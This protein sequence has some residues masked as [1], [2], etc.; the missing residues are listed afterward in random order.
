MRLHNII[1]YANRHICEVLPSIMLTYHSG[2]FAIDLS[3]LSFG[4]IFEWSKKQ[5]GETR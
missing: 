1:I 5:K 3:W 4:V 2:E